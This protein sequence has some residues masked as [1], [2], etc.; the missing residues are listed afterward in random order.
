M[1]ILEEKW[2]LSDKKIYT[3]KFP[4]ISLSSLLQNMWGSSEQ[5]HAAPFRVVWGSGKDPFLWLLCCLL[6]LC[7]SPHLH[8]RRLNFKL[9]VNKAY[10][11]KG[12]QSECWK[13]CLPFVSSQDPHDSSVSTCNF[14]CINCLSS[15]EFNNT[16]SQPLCL[17][18]E[19]SR[20]QFWPKIHNGKRFPN[21]EPR[22]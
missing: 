21:Q 8:V 5:I 4:A 18:S 20:M 14:C 22:K 3:T 6:G 16:R 15:C 13:W 7:C 2:K 19:Q 9:A 17:S 10:E 11:I 12:S 1:C